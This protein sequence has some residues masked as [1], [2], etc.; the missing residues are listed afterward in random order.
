MKAIRSIPLLAATGVL[1]MFTGCVTPYDYTDYRAH[2]PRS[3]L[4]LPPLNESADVRATYGYLSKVTKPIAELGYYVFP[5]AVVDQVMKENGLPTAAEMHGVSLKKIDEVI[6]ADAVLY[7]T[8]KE[9][10]S[11]YYV[12]T[13]ITTVTAESK[14]VDVKTGTLIWDGKDTSSDS[15][16]FL[17]QQMIDDPILGVFVA[18]FVQAYNN[19]S[20]SA[21]DVSASTSYWMF[22]QQDQGLL[23]GP[24]GNDT[25]Q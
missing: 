16:S 17:C 15:G 3:I 12:I 10:G 9:Y 22:N 4:I 11:K 20:D 21:H 24:Y 18:P 2:P 8:V 5:V 13:S 7:T 19:A 1:M 25:Q 23:P 14:L 6:G